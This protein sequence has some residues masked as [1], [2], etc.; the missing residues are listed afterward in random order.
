MRQAREILIEWLRTMNADRLLAFRDA[1]MQYQ[2]VRPPQP[3]C[4]PGRPHRLMQCEWVGWRGHERGVTWGK[5]QQRE[6]DPVAWPTPR[7]ALRYCSLLTLLL[8]HTRTL[9]PPSHTHRPLAP[10]RW[11]S[12]A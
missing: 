8:P 12:S 4:R 7:L 1:L 10:L 3:N 2:Q 11:S 5:A 6:A 9:P